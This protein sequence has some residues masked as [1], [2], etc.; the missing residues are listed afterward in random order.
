M[1]KRIR[2]LLVLILVISGFHLRAQMNDAQLWLSA[3]VEKKVTSRF[4]A[5]F[6]EELRLNENMTEAGTTY[7][8]LGV[9]YRFVKQFKAAAF[10]R[11]T[12]KRRVDD[13]YQ[14]ENSWYV[15]GSY[16]EKFKPVGLSLR[17]RYQSKYAEAGTAEKAEIP[18]SH[19]RAKVTVK[20]DL[21][22]KIEPY[23]Y[24]EAFF[25]TGVETSKSFDQLRL[26]GG[27][28]YTFNRMHMIDVHYLFSR[29][30][31]VKH[32]ETN[33]VIGLAYYFTF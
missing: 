21:K 12:M 10:Y 30:Y 27:I 29:E 33:Y 2:H 5:L 13:T 18:T 16:R 14:R 17:L 9:S 15:E 11:F 7:S 6:T 32:P 28:E 20:Y 23:L 24:A 3:N 26:C 1:I 31:H 25:R 22:K 8:D 4:S 19:I